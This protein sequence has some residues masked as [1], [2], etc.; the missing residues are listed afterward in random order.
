MR[1]TRS[2]CPGG[3]TW[4]F[5]YP[6]VVRVFHGSHPREYYLNNGDWWGSLPA[7]MDSAGYPVWEAGTVMAIFARGAG[8]WA[9]AAPWCDSECGL[10]LLG[11]SGFPEFND[12]TYSGGTCPGGTGG[13]AWPCVPGGSFVHEL[14]HTL[15]LLHPADV[16]ETESVASHSVMQTHW[17]Y[18]DYASGSEMPWG[19]LTLE[20]QTVWQNPFMH[21][22]LDLVQMHTEADIVNLPATG[23]APTAEFDVTKAGKTVQTINHSTGA[24]HCYWTFGDGNMSTASAPSHTYA[25]DGIYHISLRTLSD[26]GMMALDTMTVRINCCVGMTGNIDC[27]P[28][29]VVSLGDL[30]ALID[31]LFISL[32]PPCCVWEAD[33]D[34]NMGIS[35]GDLTKLIDHLFISLNP[36]P[37]CR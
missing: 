23:F 33:I 29:Q 1:A 4:R 25:V 16:P 26:N 2:G 32:A 13:G 31:H 20:R 11:I 6:E 37:D 36:L 7:E 24:D 34:G 12:S 28:D 15:G 14:G 27:S 9:G 30:T 3:V 8:W 21:E 5:A 22:G 19:L 17:N 35:L 18:P 10:A